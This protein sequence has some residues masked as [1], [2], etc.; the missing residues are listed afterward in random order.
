MEDVLARAWVQIRWEEDEPHRTKRPAHDGR[1]EERRPKRQFQPPDR[2]TN[3]R[4]PDSYSAPTRTYTREA[5]RPLGHQAT[6]SDDRPA[7]PVDQYRIPEYNLNI[8]PV[9]VVAIMKNMGNAVRVINVITGGSEISGISYSAARRH[10]RVSVNPETCS[11][12]PP[13]G[14]YTDQVIS[15]VDNEAT[16]LI[17]PH[18]DALVISLLVA[19]CKI[20]RILV[21]NGSSTNVLFLTALKEMKIDESNIRRCAT[22]LVG[23][24]GE[25][26]F[27]V[28]DIAL[29]VYAGGINLNVNFI[30][31]D[32]PSAYNMILGRPWIHKMRAVPSTFHQVVR[33]PTK[34]GIKEIKGEQSISRECYRNTLKAKPATL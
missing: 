6:K 25:Q 2:R 30:V 26:K 33:F 27:T 24:S 9:E 10:A 31:L 1:S 29:P 17:N 34:W 32:S 13:A 7:A 14:D 20:K 18:H 4:R 23:F 19:N 21:D 5:R 28:G 15:F 3:S 11:S 12:Q 22:V 8:E 16:A